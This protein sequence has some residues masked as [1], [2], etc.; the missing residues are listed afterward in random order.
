[1]QH[2]NN[3]TP[4]QKRRRSSFD[5][6]HEYVEKSV[7]IY[8]ENGGKVTQIVP[9]FSTVDTTPDQKAVDDFLCN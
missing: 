6:D 5:P 8:F 9:D 2:W 3:K 4:M 7:K 1:M